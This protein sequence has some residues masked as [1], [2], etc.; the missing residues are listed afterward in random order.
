MATA[1][2]LGTPARVSQ[3]RPVRRRF[4]HNV[5]Y[6][7]EVLRHDVQTR[8]VHWGVAIFFCLSLLSGFALFTPWLYKWLTPFFGGGPR[9]RLLHPWF[10][11][12]FVVFMVLQLRVWFNS[13]RWRE[14]DRRWMR[15]MGA[16]VTNEERT[17]PEDVG[18]FNGGQK[19]WFW[20]AVFSAIAFVITGFP[21]WFPEIFGRA[22]MWISYFIHDIAGLLMLGGFWIHI[23]EGTAGRPGTF[24][25]M[26]AGTVT[27]NWAWT[28]HP[29]WYRE[30]TGRDPKADREQA[31]LRQR[32]SRS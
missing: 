8:V 18:K 32:K 12:G 23:Y 21:L 5:V 25:S 7:G 10:G 9:A 4:G 26:V 16:Y 17:E 6:E 14:G 3:Q 24:R 1:E 22:L 20:V 27:E 19:V 29:A 15:R 28:H 31:E 30:I 11:L 13:M 2:P